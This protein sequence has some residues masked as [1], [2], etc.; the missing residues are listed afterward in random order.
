MT[1]L[2]WPALLGAMAWT[3]RHRRS[4]VVRTWSPGAGT[5]RRAGPLSVRVAGAGP[6]TTVLLHGLTAS[7]DAFGAG[8]DR[9]AD[10]GR[11]VV[12]DLLGFA[13]SMDEQRADFSLQAHLDA[14][15][16]MAGELGLDSIPLVVGGH[17]MGAVLALHWAAR[18]PD[19]RRVVAFCAPLYT[20]RDEA[21]RHIREMGRR[22]ALFALEGRAARLACAWMCRWRGVARWIAVVISPRWPAPLARQ[23]VE[24][25]WPSYLGGMN[26]II[27]NPS[28]HDALET[29]V[30][31][32]VDVVLV[33]G[34]ADRVPVTGRAQQLVAELPAIG[35]VT[36]PD[37]T[38]HLPIA[39]P[40]WSSRLLMAHAIG[41]D[42]SS[43]SPS[44]SASDDSARAG[45]PGGHSPSL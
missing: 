3:V 27:R 43:T 16:A 25:T 13:S 31:E 34:A 24:H 35:L 7:G 41:G 29:L 12:P 10:Q 28:W 4:S 2:L 9:V 30:A 18:R 21:D 39:D 11:L 23:G 5:Y 33:Q 40:G 36:H 22:E 17:S 14:L 15:D 32:H 19:I 44:G 1:S 26:G 38:H 45:T 42:G 8:W 20:D 6:P 37:G